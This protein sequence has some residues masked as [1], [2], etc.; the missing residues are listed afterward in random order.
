M[1]QKT[2]VAGHLG[3]DPEMRFTPSGQPV[4]TFTVAANRRWTDPQGQTQERTTWFR[5]TAWGKLGELCNQYL[6]KG[7]SVLVEGEVDTSAYTGQDGQPHSTLE[8]TARTVRFLG[9]AGENAEGDSH[10]GKQPDDSELPP[11]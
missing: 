1:Y 3:R 11:F 4:T 6:V 2:I 9:G 8:L 5:V 7:R 10:E